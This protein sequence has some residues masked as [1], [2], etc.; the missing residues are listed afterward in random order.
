VHPLFRLLQLRLSVAARAC[1]GPRLWVLG[2]L[3]A[4][5]GAGAQDTLGVEE[6]VRLGVPQ[7]PAVQAAQARFT[8]AEAG[9]RGAGAPFN[10]QAELAPGVGFTNGNGVLS[11][12]LDIGGLR[13]AQRRA[14][15]GERAAARAE[16][17]LARLHAAAEVRLAYFRLARAERT[18]ATAR[19]LARLA[20]QIRDLVRRKVELGEAPQVQATRAEIE[21]ARAEQEAA[22]ALGEVRGG[23]AT[24]NLLLGR[25]PQAPL[26]PRDVLALPAAAGEMPLLVEQARG[27]RPEIA[28]ARG[29]VQAR[30]GEVDLAQAQRRPELFVEATADVWSLDRD[31]FR[32]RNLGLQARLSFPLLD[33]G[34]LR[35]GVD[36]ARAGVREQEAELAGAERAV[37]IEVERAAADLAAAR[38]MALNYQQT[39]LPQS[40][41]LLQAT[42][43]GFESGLT[44]FLE[45]VESQRVVRQARAEY[46]AALFDAVRARINLDRALGAMPGLEGPPTLPTPDRKAQ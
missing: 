12:Q 16:L 5:A 19:E 4:A 34:S 31:P 10:P 39:I 42:Q 23:A 15:A 3:A 27:A 35:A 22:R 32:S 46:L 43:R 6:A 25:D 33:R 7:S 1:P 45:V 29:L 17:D 13:A 37:R 26:A 2:A 8:A 21:V 28:V 44:S 36:R 11:Q 38:D 18:A 20:G 40:E 30:R 41:S 14:A 9:L 24:L